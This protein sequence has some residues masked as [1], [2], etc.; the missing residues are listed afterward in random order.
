MKVWGLLLCLFL[1]FLPAYA[2]PEPF[3]AV[4]SS[5]DFDETDWHKYHPNIHYKNPSW[6][7][8]DEFLAQVAKEAGDRPITL[9]IQCH[10]DAENTG[11]FLKFGERNGHPVYKECTAGYLFNHIEKYLGKKKLTVCCEACYGAGVYK[12]TIRGNKPASVASDRLVENCDHV[13]PF[14]IFGMIETISSYN[15]FI[16]LQYYHHIRAVFVDYRQYEYVEK[17]RDHDG[18]EELSD[19]VKSVWYT[20]HSF[21][22]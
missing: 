22:V 21:G 18:N 3:L 16:F 9:D 15:N 5:P 10:G 12:K 4:Y 6:R 17:L 1:F 7:A 14:P 11:Y 8:F 20:L 2:E 19:L 13:P